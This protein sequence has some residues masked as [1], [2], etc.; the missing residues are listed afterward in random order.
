MKLEDVGVVIMRYIAA[1]LLLSIF[2]GLSGAGDST[3]TFQVKDTCNDKQDIMFKFYDETNKLVWPSV[4]KSYYTEKYNYYSLN[5]LS[6]SKGANICV[7]GSTP[8]Y[9]KP[10]GVGINNDSSCADCCGR[11]N[12]GSIYLVKL[13]CPN[14]GN[15]AGKGYLCPTNKTPFDPLWIQSHGTYW[16]AMDAHDRGMYS[17]EKKYCQVA[18]SLCIAAT[19]AVNCP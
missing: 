6:C 4:N 17:L 2:P 19:P 14:V 5:R 9:S 13:A 8:D 7:G 10:F 3:V 11:C 16:A 18:Y 12:N 1:F 15:S